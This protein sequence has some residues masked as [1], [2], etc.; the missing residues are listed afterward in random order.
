[1]DVL[2]S[3]NGML[4]KGL[5]CGLRC[6]DHHQLQNVPLET[7]VIGTETRELC[8]PADAPLQHFNHRTVGLDF[9]ADKNNSTSTS[10]QPDYRTE[11]LLCVRI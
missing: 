11:Q 5:G 1:M 8:W 6:K 4:I 7:S 3:L 9:A 10:L 2:E